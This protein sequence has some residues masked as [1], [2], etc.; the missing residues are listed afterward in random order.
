MKRT[1]RITIA[2]LVLCF[3]GVVFFMC[4]VLFPIQDGDYPYPNKAN[5]SQEQ[6]TK[7]EI[8]EPKAEP[9]KIE[10]QIIESEPESKIE[11]YESPINL[12]EDDRWFIESVMAGECAYE[13]YEGKLAVAQCYFDAMI[14]GGLTAREVK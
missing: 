6:E 1:T 2:G 5:E 14:K 12:T 9:M 11:Y 4:I 10:P 7:I 3:L 13:P 8:Y